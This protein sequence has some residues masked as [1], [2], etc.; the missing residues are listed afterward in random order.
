MYSLLI[1]C[2]NILK[3]IQT[4]ICDYYCK[5]QNSKLFKVMSKYLGFYQD[6]IIAFD[7]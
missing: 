6:W 4:Q 5:V 2:P 7:I 3:C 1:R